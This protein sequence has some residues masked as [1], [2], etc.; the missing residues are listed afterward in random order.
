MRKGLTVLFSLIILCT[1]LAL[2]AAEFKGRVIYLKDNVIEVKRKNAEVTFNLTAETSVTRQGEK[3]ALSD[4]AICQTVTVTY[5]GEGKN[6]TAQKIDIIKEA[7][8]VAPAK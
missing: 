2:S 8:C 6:R 1:S 7:D 5:K 3:A 4:L